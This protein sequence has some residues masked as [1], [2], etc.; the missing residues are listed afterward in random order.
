MASIDPEIARTQEERKKMEQ[1]LSSLTSV[2][3]DPELYGGTNKFEDYVS[4]IP[5][6][7]EE[8]NVDAMD[9]GLGRRLP[10]YTAPASLLKEMPEAVWR[11]TTWALRSRRELS[12][13]RMII[14][15]GG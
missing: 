6:N 12:I 7:D 14:G 8:E 3:Y 11:K 9:P 2:N 15:G 13:A 4:S 5:V 1:Q 10:S